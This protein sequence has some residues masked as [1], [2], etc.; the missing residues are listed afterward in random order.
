MLYSQFFDKTIKQGKK[1]KSPERGRK[2]LQT[3]DWFVLGK[4][5]KFAHWWQRLTGK[6]CFWLAKL[7]LILWLTGSAAE[8]LIKIW[9][10]NAGAPRIGLL[11]IDA[12]LAIFWYHK[13]L[14][15]QFDTYQKIGFS[16]K[17][18][19][20]FKVVRIFM[21]IATFFTMIAII[22]K[23]LKNADAVYF[24]SYLI[25]AVIAIMVF[26]MAYFTSCDPL[27]PAKSKVRQWLEK[28]VSAAKEALSPTPQPQPIP[29]ES[30]FL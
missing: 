2:M 23:L 26:S 20:E 28:V 3:I 19:L 1:D 6:D 29:V 24:S 17:N 13:I 15:S 14:S 12:L 16:N 10:F 18:K 4:F 21:A 9:L 8:Y 5:E 7:C 27:P 22:F 25:Y 11:A 30:R